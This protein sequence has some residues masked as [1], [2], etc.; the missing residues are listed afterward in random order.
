[1]V[2][3]SK[4]ES[5]AGQ[6]GLKHANAEHWPKMVSRRVIQIET[7]VRAGTWRVPQYP[8]QEVESRPAS[9]RT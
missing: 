9:I 7:S 4:R 8:Q 2:K 3:R 5:S 6:S 1:M